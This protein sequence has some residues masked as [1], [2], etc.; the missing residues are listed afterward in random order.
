MQIDSEVLQILRQAIFTSDSVKLNSQ[1]DRKLYMKVNKVLEAGTGQW[2]RK[3]GAHVFKQNPAKIFNLEVGEVMSGAVNIAGILDAIGNGNGGDIVDDLFPT[4]PDLA[5]RMVNYADIKPGQKVLEPSA[6]TGNILNAIWNQHGAT[7]HVTSIEIDP[8]LS[9]LPSTAD[10]VICADFMEPIE[11]L[12]E[13]DR[14]LL[15]PPFGNQADVRHIMRAYTC[16]KPAGRLVAICADGPRQNGVLKPM[17]EA[18]GGIWEPLPP[19]TFKRTGTAVNTV[20]IVMDRDD[21]AN[22]PS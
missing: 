22:F 14:V 12:G 3:R 17:V 7:V 5:R 11:G 18:L 16:L 10:K 1:L 20:L 9:A 2:N 4:P 8:R 13:F 6:G 21:T 15:N 19:N